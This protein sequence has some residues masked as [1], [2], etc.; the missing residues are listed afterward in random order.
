MLICLVLCHDVKG[1]TSKDSCVASMHMEDYA[2][3]RHTFRLEIYILRP[4]IESTRAYLYIFWSFVSF[5]TSAQLTNNTM[6][7]Q[8]V[9][10]V[11]PIQISR[12]NS[13]KKKKKHP[14]NRMQENVTSLCS[15]CIC[16][17]VED[18]TDNNVEVRRKHG[19]ANS[20]SIK[21]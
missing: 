11:K 1:H 14:D 13:V 4:T 7:R 6:K 16:E 19:V 8:V 12:S 3:P 20:V 17:L 9:S 18:S 10:A 15:I 5:Y 2:F 21:I